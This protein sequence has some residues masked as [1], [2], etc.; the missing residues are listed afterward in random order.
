MNRSYHRV[1]GEWVERPV[2]AGGVVPTALPPKAWFDY[3][4]DVLPEDAEPVAMRVTNDGRIYGYA[5]EWGVCHIGV[6]G[7]CTE[8]PPSPS[9]YAAFERH[10]RRALDDGAEVRVCC[11]P[12]TIGIGHASH[13]LPPKQVVS[14]YDRADAV[15]ADA[16]CYENAR[17]I[18][19]AGALRSYATSERIEMLEGSVLSGDWRP[20]FEGRNDLVALLAVPVGGFAMLR[21]TARVREGEV[22]ALT[23][24]GNLSLPHSEAA[25]DPRETGPVAGEVRLRV[26]AARLN[27]GVDGML[28]LAGVA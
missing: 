8:P 26:L 23:A 3:P 22:V 14:H 5:A 19:F 2:T 18:V 1:A 6:E 9:Q 11:G 27:G 20:V 12:I 4:A 16:A 28:A 25:P 24:A 13:S 21:P 10:T 7:A 15:I 17:G